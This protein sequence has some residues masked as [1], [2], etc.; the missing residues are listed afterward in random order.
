MFAAEATAK[1]HP[2]PRPRRAHR[3][4]GRHQRRLRDHQRLV[5]RLAAAGDRR[6]GAGLPLGHRRPAGARPPAAGRVGHQVRGDGRADADQIG[7]AS[8]R[9]ASTLASTAHR[10]PVFLDVPMDVLFYRAD[11]GGPR[12]APPPPAARRTPTTS[13]RSPSCSPPPSARCWS[14]APTSGPTAPRRP[15]VRL[16]ETAGLPVI[17]NGMGRG[18]LPPGHPLL[19]TRARSA[20]FGQADLVV[21]VG[22]PLDFR[23]GY[24]DFGGADGAARGPRRAPGR[25]ARPARRPR[26]PGRLGGRRPQPGARR[27]AR[28][29]GRSWSRR[30]DVRR[31]GRRPARPRRRGRGRATPPMLASDSDPIHPARIYGE[32]LPQLADDA[33]VIGDGGDFVSFAG[34][35]VEPARPG[36]LARPGPVRLPRHRPGLRDRRAARPPVRAGGAAARRRRGRLLP[37]GRRHPRPPQ[38]AGGDGGRQQR[39]L[40]PGEAPDAVPAT[41]TTWSP[42]CSRRRATTRS[43]APSAATARRSPSPARSAPALRPRV[44]RPDVPYLVNVLTDPAI[45]YPRATTGV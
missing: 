40:G 1:L 34:K 19:V 32:L 2:H 15:P 41:A 44:R 42:T 26:R 13:P 27:P 22:T 25:L 45:A 37:H 16:A 29:R 28:R 18:V 31:L 17:A 5:Q 6:P 35:F 10:G 30:P 23:L 4:P 21:V 38:A 36:R 7:A 11:V 12:R 8:Q 20:A 3:R 43:C 39:H 24:G 9:R 33:V 14:S